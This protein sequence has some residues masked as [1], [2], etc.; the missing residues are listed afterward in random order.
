MVIFIVW[1]VFILLE[2]KQELE[3]HKRVCENKDFCNESMSPEDTKIIEFNQF[4]KSDR[5]PFIIYADLEWI[6]KKIDG[7]KN[8]P[9]NSSTKKASEHIPLSFSIAPI[10]SFRSKQKKHNV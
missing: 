4:K 5:A 3:S 6:M 10:S 8:N 1:I 7:C 9:E 2:Q